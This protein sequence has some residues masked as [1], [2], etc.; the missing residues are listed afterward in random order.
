MRINCLF[1]LLSLV[2]GACT[3]RS[4]ETVPENTSGTKAVERKRPE[5]A[6]EVIRF[7]E[8][9][10][11]VDHEDFVAHNKLAS[12][13]LQ[14]MRET[15][16]IEYLDMALEAARTSLAILPAESNKGGLAALT[17]AEF[18]SHD[19]VN[20]RDHARLLIEIDPGKS[21]GYQLLGDVLYELGQYDEAK[22]A[23]EQMEDLGGHSELT[24]VAVEQR[25]AK[26][27]MIYGERVKARAHMMSA[28][29][30][31]ES[32]PVESAETVA[33]CKWQLGEMS[34]AEGDFD[35]A[36]KHF[37]SALKTF[38]GHFAATEALG[39]LRAARG[40]LQGAIL[41]YQ[42]AS[43][44]APDPASVAMLGDLYQLTG[45]RDDA[46]RQYAV[47][48]QLTLAADDN[49]NLHGREIAMFYANHDIKTGEACD[50]AVREY[51]TR[52]DIYGADVVA[53]ACYKAGR[54]DEARLAI[55]D[56]LRLGTKDAQ[57]FYHAGMIEKELG[58]QNEARRFLKLSLKT[59][60]AFDLLQAEKARDVLAAMP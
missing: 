48:E 1:I 30:V 18:S 32:L 13:Y 40:D 12:A 37:N 10:I 44:E 41:S 28:L 3:V 19:F 29:R 46:A 7:L 34:M 5:P 8:A 38:P 14:Q 15:G 49:K 35:G 42:K 45:R 11:K 60:P 26:L 36:E 50:S 4:V 25:W 31:A 56:A 2:M 55:G 39:H 23:Y 33:W 9:K 20:A 47:F 24:R 52:R 54:T 21:R 16:N 43:E 17:H 58:N 57:L 53:W 22:E 27:A 51:E 6:N 59:N